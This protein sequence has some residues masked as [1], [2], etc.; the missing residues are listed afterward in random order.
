[1]DI[2]ITFIGMAGAAGLLSAYFLLSAGKLSGSQP[3]YHFLNL[4]SSLFLDI[5]AIYAGILPFIVINS[6]WCLI[7]VYGLLRKKPLSPK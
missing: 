4:V 1:M 5:Q 6:A 2:L 7:S 3:A